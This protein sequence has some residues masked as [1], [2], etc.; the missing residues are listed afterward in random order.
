VTRTRA[1]LEAYA[2][3]RAAEQAREAR[4][5]RR[6]LRWLRREVNQD[7]R[8]WRYDLAMDPAWRARLIA[9]C[10]AKRE[11]LRWAE[12]WQEVRTLEYA[13]AHYFSERPDVEA[14]LLSG[15][16]LIMAAVRRV[17]QG[18]RGRPGWRDE[19]DLP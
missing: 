15:A 13:R 19:W 1:Q 16:Q 12:G 8:H 14:T 3:R 6:L 10:Q 5:D 11:L 17:A 18:Y 9:D 7:L 2:A 4:R